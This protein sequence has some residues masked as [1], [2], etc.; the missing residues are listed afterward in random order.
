MLYVRAMR[1]A[2]MAV[3]KQ[4]D[5]VRAATIGIGDSPWRPYMAI[6]RSAASVL[7]GNPVEGPPRWMFTTTSGSSRLTAR[8]I[9]SPFKA[10]PGPLVV[11]TAR[12]PP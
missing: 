3:S 1:A 2:S 10:R 12:E 5:G 4:S 7:V 8:P 9:A 6:I 11:V